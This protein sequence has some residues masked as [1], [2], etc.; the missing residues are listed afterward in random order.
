MTAP[1]W[2]RSGPPLPSADGDAAEPPAADAEAAD[3]GDESGL[4]IF[5]A[6]PVPTQRAR[7]SASDETVVIPAVAPGSGP[8][9]GYGGPRQPVTA[10][11]PVV[12]QAGSAPAPPRPAAT[13][14]APTPA[15]WS[16]PGGGAA[17]QHHQDHRPTPTEQAGYPSQEHYPGQAW[18]P[19]QQYH[20]AYADEDRSA[21]RNRATL[22]GAVVAAGVAVV[23]V[24]GLGAVVL[25]RDDPPPSGTAPTAVAPTGVPTAAG[26]P[27]GDLKLRDDSTTITLTWTDPSGGAVPFMVAAG[28]AGQALGVMATV[29]PG[30][31]SYTV[32]GLNSR[33]DHCFTVLA[34]YSTDSFATSG[35]VCTARERTAP[36]SGKPSGRPSPS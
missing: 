11:G 22:I 27:P 10:Q 14:V 13:P 2:S 32:N 18:Y 6:T 8:P 20:R 36:S 24:A 1:P 30:R 21:G 35:Q 4:D 3:G 23:A 29:D 33:V 19:G 25:T 17:P 5:E 9:S 34:V 26:P 31:T 12:A 16:P 7:V 28:R 15:A